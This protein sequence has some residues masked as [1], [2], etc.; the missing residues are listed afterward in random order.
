MKTTL[1]LLT[2]IL[3]SGCT[4]NGVYDAKKTWTLVGV[5]AVG[6]VAASQNGGSKDKGPDC[7]IAIGP[8]GS[9]HI[10]K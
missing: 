8:S 4:T 2:L 5:V 1:A 6:G 7:Y 10:C 9:D 3:L